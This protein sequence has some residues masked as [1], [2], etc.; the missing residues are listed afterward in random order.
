MPIK[1]RE[2]LRQL[3]DTRQKLKQQNKEVKVLREV[4]R[5]MG[6]RLECFGESVRRDNN[7][8]GRESEEYSSDLLWQ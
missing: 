4:M 3:E 7:S 8:S 5:Y 1:L 6:K 2:V